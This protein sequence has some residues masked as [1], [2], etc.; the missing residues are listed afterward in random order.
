MWSRYPSY[1]IFM[2][3]LLS[4]LVLPEVVSVCVVCMYGSGCYILRQEF[5]RLFVIDPTSSFN[6]T[7]VCECVSVSEWVLSK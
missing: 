1:L 6:V 2:H 5:L 3:L 4:W 7:N